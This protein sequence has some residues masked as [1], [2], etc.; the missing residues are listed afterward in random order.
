MLD[1]KE[2][3]PWSFCLPVGGGKPQALNKTDLDKVQ[4]CVSVIGYLESA[5]LL[6]D[7]SD[8]AIFRIESR[9]SEPV[10]S[11]PNAHTYRLLIFKERADWSSTCDASS[12]KR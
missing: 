1:F 4:F 10:C 3:V 12:A 2:R 9:G 8:L 6:N 5:D 11:Y 7:R